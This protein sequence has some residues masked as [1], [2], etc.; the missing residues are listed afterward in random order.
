MNTT[1]T[2]NENFNILGQ[3][4]QISEII[5][6]RKQTVIQTWVDSRYTRYLQ[7]FIRKSSEYCSLSD[8][9]TT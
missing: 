5:V 7:T 3:L 4:L 9:L 2:E 8:N 1:R 6:S